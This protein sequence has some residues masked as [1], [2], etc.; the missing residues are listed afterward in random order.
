MRL[1][2]ISL[3]TH[4]TNLVRMYPN[5]A[6]S[7]TF[8]LLLFFLFLFL[9]SVHWPDYWCQRF[10]SIFIPKS[11]IQRIISWHRHVVWH[12][13]RTLAIIIHM[14]AQCS[15]YF[16]IQTHFW[17]YI[18][19]IVYT[20]SNSKAYNHRLRSFSNARPGNYKCKYHYSKW[21]WIEKFFFF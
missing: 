18:D 12:S 8:F 19:K 10:D 7:L 3:A 21:K 13:N 9:R 15:F 2:N 16:V 4:S 6:S 1:N 14:F 11:S 17:W 20:L 5:I